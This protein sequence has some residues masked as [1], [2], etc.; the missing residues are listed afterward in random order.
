[1]GGSMASLG[2]QQYADAGTA[3]SDGSSTPTGGSQGLNRGPSGVSVWLRGFGQWVNVDADPNAAGYDQDSNGA[4]GGIDY[5]VANNATIGVAGSWSNTEADFD[6][7]GD[8][9]EMDS[10]TAGAYGSVGFGRFY[11][12]GLA[13]YASHDVSTLRTIQ[14]PVP[15]APFVAASDY[16]A[17]AWSAQGEFGMMFRLGRANIQPSVGLAYS[18]LS[19]DAFIETG[20]GG[21]FNLLVDEASA[22]SFASTVA[23]RASGEW[24]MGRTR[25]MPEFRIGWR[26][27]F[28]NDPYSFTAAFDEDPLTQFTIVSS[29]LQQ[30]S[31][32]VRAGATFG[33]SRNIEVFVNLNGQYS[34]DA[35]ATAGSGGL[36]LTW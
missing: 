2:G 28:E 25:V 14:S 27:E 26:H 1:M 24:K 34:A 36:R 33:V 12:D 10:W 13:S 8:S 15:N 9:S 16:N 32:V 20:D 31:A 3:A 11:V 23:L 18:D 29:E 7:A 22:D 21:V 4:A 17:T 6:T 35:A 5:A 19:T 30:D